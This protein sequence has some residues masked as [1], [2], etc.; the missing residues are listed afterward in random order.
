MERARG[1]G[2][3]AMAAAA[4]V[5]VAAVVLAQAPAASATTYT[6]G[7]PEGLWD[8]ETDY[9]EWV[10]RR[11]F[12]PGD[13]LT[14]TYSRELHDVVE[15][16]KAG[17]EACSNANNISAFRSGNDVVALTAVG[18]RYFLC[19]LTGHCDSGMKIRIDV[20]ATSASG[21]VAGPS[22]APLPSTSSSSASLPAPPATPAAAV[23]A[24][25]LVL[26]L[27]YAL[28]PLW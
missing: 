6:V 9:N 1:G 23:I 7:A 14:F 18:T 25:S 12:H 16:T 8:M 4:A 10:A 2:R 21:P 15:V 3:A 27:L 26:V 19:G 5:M 11:T 22:A 13:K 20:V 17:Y 24:G 28:L